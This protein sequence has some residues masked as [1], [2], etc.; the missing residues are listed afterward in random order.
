MLSSL[1]ITRNH[2]KSKPAVVVLKRLDPQII[3]SF[4]RAEEEEIG[5]RESE[6]MDKLKE[7]PAAPVLI[8]D[9][10]PALEEVVEFGIA[11]I[12]AEIDN[13]AN[14]EGYV[15]GGNWTYYASEEEIEMINAPVSSDS[16]DSSDSKSV[17]EENVIMYL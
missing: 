4:E 3:K 10:I 9:D 17:P 5:R 2:T 1:D 15:S 11:I 7:A 14:D 12:D 13:F 16:S 6:D 8:E